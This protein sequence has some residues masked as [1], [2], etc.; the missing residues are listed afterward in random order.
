MIRGKLS[1]MIYHEHNLGMS[2]IQF[3]QFIEAH[4]FR[5]F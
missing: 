1:E 3:R 2:T 4:T 5:S